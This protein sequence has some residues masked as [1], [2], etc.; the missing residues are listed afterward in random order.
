MNISHRSISTLR[1]ILLSLVFICFAS[2][3]LAHTKLE[4]SIPGANAMLDTTPPELV[5]EFDKPIILMKLTLTDKMNG[6]AVNLNFIPNS[7][8]EK[9]YKLPFPKLS[10]GHYSVNWVAMGKDGH[11]MRGD[12][13]F[14]IGAMEGMTQ[15][16]VKSHVTK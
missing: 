16:D 1:Q 3:V 4:K 15:D 9:T 10:K 8:S 11:N 5:L 13:E 6:K 7:N 12:F 14:M 2:N